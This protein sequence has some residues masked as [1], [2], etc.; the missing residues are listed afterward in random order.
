MARIIGTDA[1]EVLR[2]TDRF[3]EILALAGDDKVVGGPGDD[4]LHGG[5]GDDLFFWKTGTFAPGHSTPD[6]GSDAMEGG[7]GDDTFLYRLEGGQDVSIVRAGKVAVIT[8][9]NEAFTLKGVEVIV[10][11]HHES[12]LPDARFEVGNLSGTGVEEIR[13]TGDGFGNSF[14]ASRS[15]D[16]RLIARGATGDDRFFGGR[17]D[18]QFYGGGGRDSL[19]GGGGSDLIVGG[20]GDDQLSGDG[21]AGPGERGSDRFVFAPG[22]GRD[23]VNDFRSGTDKIDFA[24]YHLRGGFSTLDT[25]HDG[26]LDGADDFTRG[27][28]F[29]RLTIDLGAATGGPAEANDV[30]LQGGDGSITA[31]HANDFFF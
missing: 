25:N 3:D 24:A 20:H 7:T 2:G 16:V 21:F 4:I 22:D 15:S 29:G 18:D 8:T 28:G 30:A 27:D 14:D 6:D 13:A 9:V 10:V 11:P 31:L 1:G 19:D 17:G 23:F 5:A 12:F 26:R